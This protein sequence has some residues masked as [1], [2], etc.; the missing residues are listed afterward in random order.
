M[1]LSGETVKEYRAALEKFESMFRDTERSIKLEDYVLLKRLIRE[2]GIKCVLEFGAGLSTILFQRLGLQ[3]T[4]FDDNDQYIKKLQ[5]VLRRKV[6]SFSFM[7]ELFSTRYDLALVDGSTPRLI[8]GSV[9]A[10]FSPLVVVHDG[11][12]GQSGFDGTR[13]VRRP[14]WSEI[15]NKTIRTRVFEKEKG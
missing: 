2:R 4:A 5:P 14:G 1:T 7:D 8:Q 11:H 9:A 12:R 15:D 6:H 3:V 13:A 10:M